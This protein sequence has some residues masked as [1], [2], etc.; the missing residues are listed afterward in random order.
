MQKI[1]IERALREVW[2]ETKLPLV[3]YATEDA[4]NI[5]NDPLSL[6]LERFVKA[7]N[8]T[9]RNELN[10]ERTNEQ[11]NRRPVFSDPISPSKRKHRADSM[12]SLDSNHAS[13]GSDGGN[14]FDNP[15]EEQPT[16]FSFQRGE[17]EP[18][19]VGADGLPA[20]T[21]IGSSYVDFADMEPGDG[22]DLDFD[23]KPPQYTDD[24]AP[25]PAREMEQLLPQRIP[26]VA[27][28]PESTE[29][30]PID[31]V[32]DVDMPSREKET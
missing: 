30:E 21:R 4:L 20:Q 13:V 1:E 11:E 18:Y 16:N 17:Y 2:Q 31:E 27:P 10:M 7:D 32:M 26:F 5:L 6:P 19:V 15:F 9:F 8:K 3:V 23:S 25:D 24:V 22:A 29:R 28:A 14:G 12:D